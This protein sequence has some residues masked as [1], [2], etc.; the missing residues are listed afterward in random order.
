MQLDDVWQGGGKDLAAAIGVLREAKKR[1]GYFDAARNTIE[2]HLVK[3][4]AAKKANRPYFIDRN[5]HEEA[6][7]LA[8]EACDEHDRKMKESAGEINVALQ[9]WVNS[10]NPDTLNWLK[11]FVY[12]HVGHA[13]DLGRSNGALNENLR[14]MHIADRAITASG[15]VK[16]LELAQAEMSHAEFA[17]V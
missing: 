8:Q 17:E 6:A 13:E 9:S 11:K 3:A 15:G 10:R 7:F 2:R 1:L 4:R 14:L 12:K 16:A 5:E